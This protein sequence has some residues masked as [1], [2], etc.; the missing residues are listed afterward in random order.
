M[1]VSNKTFLLLRQEEIK[2]LK[3]KHRKEKQSSGS[4]TAKQVRLFCMNFFSRSRFA[5]HNVRQLS[6]RVLLLNLDL[7][8]RIGNS[9]ACAADA[10]F[11]FSS[12]GAGKQAN[13]RAWGEQKRNRG[14]GGVRIG[15]IRVTEEFVICKSTRK[16]RNFERVRKT[17]EW[18][19]GVGGVEKRFFSSPPFP[20][21][22]FVN[23]SM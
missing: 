6:S 21:L 22:L 13:E 7:T 16:K 11:P 17:K 8:I 1:L 3:E 23:E 12:G 4:V 19:G 5:Q 14:G 10:L 20:P 9:L 15:T 18:G 2:F